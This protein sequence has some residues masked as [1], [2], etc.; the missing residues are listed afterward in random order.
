MAKK[1]KIPDSPPPNPNPEIYIQVKTKEGWLT[2]RKRGTVNGAA[3]NHSFSAN[4]SVTKMVSPANKR[5]REKLEEFTRVLTTGRLHAALNSILIPT[6]KKEGLLN[7]SQLKGFEFQP[8]HPLEKILLATYRVQSA[9]YFIEIQIPINKDAVRQYNR[10]VTHFYF[11]GILLYGD[12]LLEGSL[13]VEYA[14]S[15]PYDFIDTVTE[16]CKLVLQLPEKGQPWM[17]LLK[18]SCLE[19]NE[20]A[21]HPKH[22]GMKVVEVGG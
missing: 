16:D 18:V 11:E 3:L 9:N 10:L 19:G 13:Q 5:I 7:F 22:Y 2:R 14:V 12:A 17:L 21:A 6:Y 8:D 4:V 1:K 20:M 15:K